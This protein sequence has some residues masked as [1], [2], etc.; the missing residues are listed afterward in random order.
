VAEQLD[1][2]S[3]QIA[4]H[5]RDAGSLLSEAER[6]FDEETTSEHRDKWP[7]VYRLESA[8]KQAQ[9]ALTW[10]DPRITPQAVA[11]DLVNAA[12]QARDVIREAVDTGGGSLIDA[13][14]GLLKVTGQI[15]PQLL[16]SEEEANALVARLHEIQ[17]EID[18]ATGRVNELISSQDAK[19]AEAQKKWATRLDDAFRNAET[20]LTQDQAAFVQRASEAREHITELEDDISKTAAE[21]GGQG[22]AIEN[23]RE[24]EEQTAK[25]FWWTVLTVLLLIVAAGIPLF[26]GIESSNQ[27]PESV[28]GKITVALIL[29]GI[30]SYTAGVA[31]HHRRRAATARRL[32]IELNAFG[33]F[34]APLEKGDRDDLRSTIVWRFF[35]PPDA[36]NQDSDAEPTPGP[37]ILQLLSARR[38]ARKPPKPEA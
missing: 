23:Y 6:I 4:G 15:G 38:E 9:K 36:V 30:A 19:F 33:P 27:S 28:A 34:I 11:D 2:L 16:A 22:I 12:R 35:G 17:A 5:L 13:A 10:A 14:E 31:R 21:L 7:N 18:N 24:S 1:E 3:E 20:D 32:A 8:T 37:R 25:A 29:A 26:I